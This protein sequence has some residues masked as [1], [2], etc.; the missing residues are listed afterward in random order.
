MTEAYIFA[1]AVI[2]PPVFLHFSLLAYGHARTVLETGRHQVADYIRRQTLLPYLFTALWFVTGLTCSWYGRDRLRAFVSAAAYC[3]WNQT[4]D[5]SAFFR[6]LHDVPAAPFDFG[7]F[8]VAT[9]LVLQ[10]LTDKG[11]Q[12]G[13]SVG[14]V[15]I[16]LLWLLPAAIYWALAGIYFY[17]IVARYG[18][19]YHLC[20]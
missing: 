13:K 10:V 3:M 7:L 5:R 2:L 18:A 12:Q 11:R 8:S 16:T 19:W 6:S 1:F 14:Y 20:N 4:G 15:D 17:R 9:F